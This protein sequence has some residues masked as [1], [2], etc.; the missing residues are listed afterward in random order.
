MLT[1]NASPD[2]LSGARAGTATKS[3]PRLAYLDHFRGFAILMVVAVHAGN[4]V[5]QR[6]VGADLSQFNLMKELVD[7]G[8]YNSTF[9]FAFISGCLYTYTLSRK[10]FPAFM[11]TRV[12]YVWLPYAL[13]SVA[14]TL[15]ALGYAALREGGQLSPQDMGLALL[16]NI[17]TGEAWNTLWYIPVIMVIYLFSPMIHAIIRER[18][19]WWAALGIVLLPFLFPRTGTEL[20]LSMV[21]YYFGVYTI[22]AIVGSDIENILAKCQTYWLWLVAAVIGLSATIL[23]TDYLSGDPLSPDRMQFRES[24]IYL[25]RLSISVITLVAF[26]KWSGRFTKRADWTLLLLA[27]WA[28]GIYFL[29]GP[30]LRPISRFTGGLALQFGNAAPNIALALAIGLAFLIALILSLAIIYVLKKIL[31]RYSKFVIGS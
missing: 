21:I 24:L 23:L 16:T 22:G 13:F 15:T 18:R 25:Q 26:R 1:A 17:L 2:E 20:T 5:L 28:F 3:V 7:I 4:G 6:G 9:Y 19:L 27:N 14:L 10:P 12:L 29:H 30:L 11:T 8:F 31:G